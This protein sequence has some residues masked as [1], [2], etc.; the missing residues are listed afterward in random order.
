ML[1]LLAGRQPLLAIDE[2]QV[3]DLLVRAQ[4]DAWAVEWVFRTAPA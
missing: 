1:M 2:V 3:P 4:V